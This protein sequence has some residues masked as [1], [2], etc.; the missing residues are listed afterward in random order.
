MTPLYHGVSVRDAAMMC[1]V[2]EANVR[3][4]LRRGVL[5]RTGDGRICP[6]SLRDWWDFKRDTA[7]AARNNE[8]KTCSNPYAV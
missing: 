5:Q 4:W 1:G 3:D 2:P 6:F 7:K 8:S